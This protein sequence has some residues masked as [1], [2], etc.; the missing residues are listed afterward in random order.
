MKRKGQNR[1]HLIPK[2]RQGK[3]TEANLLW[4]YVE[5]HRMWHTLFKNLTLDEVIALL[6]RV[7]R[8]KEYLSR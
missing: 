5:K 7:K 3:S 8:M 2:S 4:I 1:H 6:I